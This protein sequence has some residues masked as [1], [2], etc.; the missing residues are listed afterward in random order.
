MP[1]LR[2]SPLAQRSSAPVPSAAV[3]TAIRAPAAARRAAFH[4]PAL[5]GLRGAA[6]LGV[7]AFHLAPLEHGDR[8]GLLG[9]GWLG[10]DVFFTL[11]GYLITALLLAELAER[12]AVDLKAFWRRRI[13]R[14]Q[15][16]ALVTV[17]VIALTALWW[18]PAGTA[19]SVR[20]EAL[21]ALGGVANWHALWTDRPYAAGADPSGF[22]HFWSLAV[23]EQFYLVWPVALT[24][25]AFVLRRR[26]RRGRGGIRLPVLL[27]TSCGVVASWWL[28]AHHGLQRGYLGTDA[29]AG[30]I[31]LGAALAAVLPMGRTAVSSLGVRAARI[32][33]WSGLVTSAA[34]WWLAGWPPRIPLSIVLPLQG[35]ASVAT[36][37]GALLAPTSRPATALAS[38]PLVVVGRVSYGIYLWH[39]PVFVL[40]TPSRL[41]TGWLATTIV[42]LA[43]LALLVTVSWLVVEHPVR[44]G[45]R[46]PRTRVAFPVGVA[47]VA[48]V[49]VLAVRAVDPTPVWARADGSL[50]QS[51][52][53]VTAPR[54]RQ[55]SGA[56]VRASRVSS[57][58]TRSRR[59]SC[60]DPPTRCRW[61]PGVC[62]TISPSVALPRRQRRSPAV[63]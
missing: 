53:E 4:V 50:V 26:R 56:V 21:S 12:G 30:S 46:F 20:G 40:L 8:R 41:G 59:H 14:L 47:T 43:L 23:E 51:D 42:R 34:L 27:L 3:E 37:A 49:A 44:H 9:G 19:S 39:W 10:V 25:L 36:L 45:I 5:D 11:S 52:K 31:L 18:A 55:M 13:R 2:I 54:A 7:V 38:R 24:A 17:G 29:R 1:T 48:V 60:L 61:R 58:A 16:A 35:L 15:P 57:S 6:V 63:P 22:E 32:S 28:L 62:S 33:L